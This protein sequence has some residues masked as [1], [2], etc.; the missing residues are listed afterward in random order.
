MFLFFNFTR[1]LKELKS[2]EINI[3]LFIK[4]KRV[5]VCLYEGLYFNMP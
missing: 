5:C 3:Y 2:F 1:G 4:N